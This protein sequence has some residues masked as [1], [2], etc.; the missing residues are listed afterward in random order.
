MGRIE[1]RKWKLGSVVV[2]PRAA[3]VLTHCD[4]R[5]A[6]A[7]HLEG[8]WGDVDDSGRVECER[9]LH[10]GGKLVSIYHSAEGTRFL[11]ITEA[12]RSVT[13]VLLPSDY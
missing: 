4:V 7:K 13:T 11:V 12:D 2:T 8:D 5:N 3:E 1:N 6:V 9:S 10:R